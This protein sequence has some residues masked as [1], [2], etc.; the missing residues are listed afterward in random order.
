MVKC[1]EVSLINT[2][3]NVLFKEKLGVQKKGSFNT[4]LICLYDTFTLTSCKVFQ[5]K[6]TIIKQYTCLRFPNG[7][8]TDIHPHCY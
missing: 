7:S 3:T 2:D 4:V 1:T 6:S 5:T 8:C